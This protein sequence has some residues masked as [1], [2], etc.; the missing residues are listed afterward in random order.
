MKAAYADPPYLGQA[1]K[2]YASDPQCA[3]VDHAELI[4][5][6]CRD[7]DAWAFREIGTSPLSAIG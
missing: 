7:Y 4:G 5:R 6:L 2:H 3:E 1:R